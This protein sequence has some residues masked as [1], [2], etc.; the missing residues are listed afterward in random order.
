MITDGLNP[1]QTLAVRTTEGPLLVLAG[2]GSGKTSVLTRRIA[3]IIGER[4][5]DPWNVLAITF[6]NKAAREMNER[7][8]KLV[9]K[10]AGDIWIGTFH[11]ICVKI[12]RR[13]AE[14]IGY[15]PTFTILD[16]DDQMTLIKQSM[17]DL[18]YDLKQYE[19]ELIHY[20]ISQ[21]KN[22]L[23]AADDVAA[24]AK[25]SLLDQ[26]V[27]S[28]YRLY[29]RR[30]KDSNAFDFDD[31]IGK[32]IELFS[33]H[34]DVLQQ[35]QEKFRYIHVDEYQDT[36][37][38]QYQLVQLLAQRYR[39]ICVVGDAD[40]A[41]YRW[42]GADISNILNFER[43][44]PEAQVVKLEQNYRSTETI[45]HAA[46]AVIRHNSQR[47]EKNLWSGN[48]KG[49]NIQIFAALDQED[50]G[51]YVAQTIQNHVQNDGK[52]QDCAVLY[53]A[54]SQSRAI[55]EAFLQA[56]IPY[57]I[58]GGM[59]FYDRRE[60]K[61]L[62]AYLKVL[63]NPQDEISLLR[64]INVPKRSIGD[65]TVKRLLDYAHEQEL[66]LLQALGHGE[67]VGLSGRAA[68]AVL[69]FHRLLEQLADMQE[70]L[71]VTEFVSLVLQRTGL[72][73]LYL[74]HPKEEERNRADNLDEFLTVTRSFDRRHPNRRVSD[75]L[76]E[77]S[78]LSDIDKG[79]D[80]EEA[81]VQMMTLHASKGLEFDVVF[82]VGF[83]EGIFP[84]Q[85][86]MFDSEGIEEERNL[87]YV[88]I[89]RARKQ[90]FITYCTER[91]I[92]G[93]MQIND[94]SRFLLEI[95][96]DLTDR[97]VSN[98]M[99]DT[100]WSIGDRVQHPKWGIGV[101]LD[102]RKQE[103]E[104]VLQIQFQSKIGCQDVLPGKIRLKRV[105]A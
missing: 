13:E 58:L 101:I 39:N 104:S 40:Q 1:E 10:K 33:E 80:Q 20:K 11:S 12:L 17:L 37:R 48:E 84:H 91:T 70:G 90:L 15:S 36:N 32:T 62:M 19:P 94:P 52:Y 31:L 41:I 9:G 14:R 35:Y 2:A 49:A 99:Y 24:T 6:T 77:V 73:D 79:S 105:D 16:S 65:S 64:I 59:T 51:F 8:V 50:E 95:P 74:H 7:I 61:N 78:L 45:L 53:R 68:Q 89:T 92:Y 75:F 34:P 97:H 87:C 22:E 44:Y 86:S 56:A 83:E 103:E 18:N 66:T 4:R 76:A 27:A 102:I 69:E 38:A 25:R 47:K 96:E 67:K 60:I 72:R 71:T 57:R 93:Q 85:R 3:Y 23:E 81:K 26:V 82:I 55:E 46:N 21:M 98:S 100:N 30:L 88:G 28:T 5:V 63:S 42:R 29:Q 54:N 43:D